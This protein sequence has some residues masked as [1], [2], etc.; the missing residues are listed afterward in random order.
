MRSALNNY[1][2]RA[3]ARDWP[4]MGAEE[5][6]GEVPSALNEFYACTLAPATI[7]S[8]QQAAAA[9]PMKS[10]TSQHGSAT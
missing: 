4:R 6:S 3:I 10:M 1:L 8:R 2:Q 7:G 5:E 9:W